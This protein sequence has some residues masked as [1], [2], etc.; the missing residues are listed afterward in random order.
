MCRLKELQAARDARFVPQ[1][2]MPASM[3][4]FPKN[5]S[6][7][8]QTGTYVWGKV[9]AVPLLFFFCISHLSNWCVCTRVQAAA[10]ETVQSITPPLKVCPP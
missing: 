10:D 6:L 9:R 3:P 2:F 8:S 7:D 1:P 4:G 5:Q